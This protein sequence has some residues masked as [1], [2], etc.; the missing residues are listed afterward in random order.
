MTAMED[1]HRRSSGRKRAPRIKLARGSFMSALWPCFLLIVPSVAVSL[2]MLVCMFRVAPSVFLPINLFIILI[3][4][5]VVR[6]Q[7]NLGQVAN[8]Q[9]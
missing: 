8:R 6:I 4:L 9:R 3:D 7:R 2:R 1:M 5:H